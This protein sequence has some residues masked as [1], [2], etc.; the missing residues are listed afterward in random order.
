M[1]KHAQD[2]DVLVRTTEYNLPAYLDQHIELI[3]PTTIFNRAKGQSTTSHFSPALYTANSSPSDEKV[4]LPGSGVTVDATCTATIT[5]TCLKQLYN[6]ADYVPKAAHNNSIG[7]TGY[8][9][10]FPNFSDL[11]QFY[12]DQVPEAVNTSFNAVLINGVCYCTLPLCSLSLGSANWSEGGLDNQNSS[13]DV[14]EANL[15]VQFALGLAF[16][17]PGTFY[18]TG[19]EPP[20][21][22]DA[23]TPNNTNEPYLDVSAHSHPRG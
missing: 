14:T 13:E 8:L 12:A 21:K 4:Y 9:G 16:P 6:A 20:F 10:W 5:V 23:K 17:T 18:S 2:G 7:I 22:P 19:G 1:W 3:Q 15:D 11:Q